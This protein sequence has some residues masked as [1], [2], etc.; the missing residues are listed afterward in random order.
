LVGHAETVLWKHILE[1]AS[2]QRLYFYAWGG[3][4][5]IN[6]YI[7]WAAE[8]VSR[9][10]GVSV[11]HVKTQDTADVV[12]QVRSEVAASKQDGSVDLMEGVPN[13]V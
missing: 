6:D 3:S 2:G 8:Q 11:T 12:R 9:Q 1:Q 7:Q 10:F 5:A 4:L 13:F